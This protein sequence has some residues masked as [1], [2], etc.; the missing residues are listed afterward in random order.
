MPLSFCQKNIE[1]LIENHSPEEQLT[2]ADAIVAVTGLYALAEDIADAFTTD[3]TDVGSGDRLYQYAAFMERCEFLPYHGDLLEPGRNVTRSEFFTML[4]GSANG[5][6][7]G[8]NVSDETASDAAITWAEAIDAFR[9]YVGKAYGVDFTA[10]DESVLRIRECMYSVKPGDNIQAVIDNAEAEAACSP[11]RAVIEFDSGTYRIASPL[12][13]NDFPDNGSE[14][15]L[16]GKKNKPV[17]TGCCDIPAKMFS[18]VDGKEYYLYRFGEE[19]KNDGEFPGFR[20]LY[21]NGQRL[22]MASGKEAVFEKS[23]RNSDPSKGYWTYDNWFYIDPGFIPDDAGSSI[24]PMELCINVEWMNKRFRISDYHGKDPESGLAQVSVFQEEWDAFLGYDGNK[25][26]FLGKTYWVENH[27]S[28]LNVPGEFFYD[29]KNGII[30]IYPYT[31]TDMENAVISY[32]V[33]ESIIVLNSSEN[34]T[35]DGLT[36]TGTTSVF[37][38]H[39][40]YDGGLGGIYLGYTDESGDRGH[41]PSAAVLG[42]DT[43]KFAIRRCTFDNLGGHGIYLDHGNRNIVIRDNSFTDLS[44]AGM[45]IGRQYPDWTEKDGLANIVIGNNY[46]CNIGTD[47]PLSP[48]IQVT[49]VLNLSVTHN[50]V[51]HTPYCGIMSGWFMFPENVMNSRN[52]E[53]QYNYCEDNMY[54]INDGAG[55]YI[56]GA[57][58]GIDNTDIFMY[59]HHNYL[60]ATGYNGTYNGIYL[61]ANASNWLVS[62]NVVDGFNTDMGPIFNQGWGVPS[63]TTYNNILLNNYSTLKEIEVLPAYDGSVPVDGRNITLSGNRFFRHSSDLPEEAIAI[64]KHSGHYDRMSDVIPT[65]E[66]EV[67][68]RTT[69]SCIVPGD[70]DSCVVFTIRNN[71]TKRA[72]YRAEQSNDISAVARIKISH[73]LSLMPGE[74]G[75]IIVTFEPV[76]GAETWAVS[77]LAIVRDNGW[78]RKYRRAV[79]I[80]PEK[81]PAEC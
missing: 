68:M 64:K 39:H 51:V 6:E 8:I 70:S 40:G 76:T 20:D 81:L 19:S 74:M 77:D 5:A 72:C 43:G 47:Y 59:C 61:D 21:L 80:V 44:M 46:I 38:D 58:A 49:R 23:L 22:K 11:L 32:P 67:I 65:K 78:R 16:T 36:F 66:N 24:C 63:Q 18:Q 9:G 33:T 4:C 35:I 41:I 48:G 25:R 10:Y 56:P 17:L 42:H 73:E 62:Y 3:F 71:G 69:D 54:A 7:C 12:K 50:T 52:V 79:R 15:I 26:D 75:R 60:K 31:D 55:I 57:N 27:L 13:V 37:V 53:I 14:L 1:S 30:Y 45:I 2:R 29:R 34:V 28:L